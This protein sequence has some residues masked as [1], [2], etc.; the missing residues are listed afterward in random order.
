MRDAFRECPVNMHQKSQNNRRIPLSKKSSDKRECVALRSL[1]KQNWRKSQ[2]TLYQEI[3]HNVGFAKS[4]YY[5]F[6]G[7]SCCFFWDRCV[8]N[9]EA[10]INSII[11]FHV[12]SLLVSSESPLNL[13]CTKNASNLQ[14]ATKKR[15]LG[16]YF[17]GIGDALHSSK[18]KVGSCQDHPSNLHRSWKRTQKH[19]KTECLPSF[20][21]GKWKEYG[22]NIAK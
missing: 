5:Y 12:C 21:G 16:N 6:L 11:M 17:R 19:I 15:S 3:L 7:M 2:S 18:I 10:Q 8:A 1:R 20:F 14:P 9:P 22:R 4:F 13:N